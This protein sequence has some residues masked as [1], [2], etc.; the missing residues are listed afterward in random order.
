ML[1]EL[2]VFL[3]GWQDYTDCISGRGLTQG[4]NTKL[5]LMVRLQFWR[6]AEGIVP[7]RFLFTGHIDLFEN[8]LY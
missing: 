2:F 4:Y 1:R 5:H 8:Y 6:Y 3:P 7:V